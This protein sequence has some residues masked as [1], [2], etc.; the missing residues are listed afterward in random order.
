MATTTKT[1][2]TEKKE[3][4]LNGKLNIIMNSIKLHSTELGFL[5]GLIIYIIVVSII[6]ANNPYDIITNSNEGVGILLTLFG[7]F[8]I[9]VLMFFYSK[10]KQLFENEKEISPLSFIGKIFTTI[11]SVGLVIT[12]IYVL[13]NLSNYFSEFSSFLMMGIN[14]LI[15]VGIITIAFKFFGLI[16][17]EPAEKTPSWSKLLIKI[18][19]YV[20]CLIMDLISYIQFQYQITTKPIV[21]LLV[22]EILLIALYFLLPWFMEKLILH[23]TSQLITQPENLN[24]QHTLGT[25]QDV[26]Y[27]AS[28]GS[29]TDEFNYHFAISGWFYINSSP[30]ETNPYYSE[31]TSILNVGDKPDIQFNV[32]KNKLRIKMKTQSKNEKIIYETTEF[33]MQKW[34]NI[35]INYDG[36]TFDIFI[37]N[38]LVSSTPGVIPYNSNTVIT[39]GTQDGLYGGI[40][41]V[42]YFR[43]NL[44]RGKINW[45]YNSIKNFNPPII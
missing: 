43:N 25:F 34:N 26:N 40:C 28:Y 18:I 3:P 35:I 32:L 1:T 20:P 4:V 38:E 6:F 29:D 36:S 19:T 39:S 7:G 33:R 44:T 10:K 9:I 5:F 8:L 27:T 2:P 41:N 21:I 23:N 13:F 12:L 22:I 16:G 30:P 45:L 17:G 42:Q 14:I 11:I 24:I 15:I 37:N 31:Y